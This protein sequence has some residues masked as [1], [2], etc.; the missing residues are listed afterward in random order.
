MYSMQRIVS[1]IRIL[2]IIMFAIV[3]TVLLSHCII[4]H[5]QTSSTSGREAKLRQTI[6]KRAARFIRL[7]E[8]LQDNRDITP[9]EIDFMNDFLKTGDKTLTNLGLK[10]KNKVGLRVN[11][12]LS[13]TPD[14]IAKFNPPA[15]GQA[16]P[17]VNVPSVDN[18]LRRFT[19]HY[20]EEESFHQSLL[21]QLLHAFMAKMEGVRNPQY[22]AKVLNFMLALASGGNRKAFEFVSANF[23]SVSLRHIAR[24]T[25][26]RRSE[27]FINVS[28]VDMVHRIRGYID[29]IRSISSGNSRSGRVA[30][31]VGI[32]ATV[33]VKAFQV[34]HSSQAIVGGAYPNHFLPIPERAAAV[35]VVSMLKDCVENKKYGLPAAEVK[36]CVISF[37][38][39]PPGICPYFP[40]VGRPQAVNENSSFG[41]DVLEACV[42]A[43]QEDG[44]AVVLNTS[45][46]GVSTEVKW[47][48]RVT[49][50]F[51]LGKRNQVSLPDTNHNVKNAR[52]QLIGGSSAAC[53]G[54]YVFDPSLLKLAKVNQKLW[55]VEDYASDALVL[56]LASSSTIQKL[57]GLLLG[58]E[59]CDLCSINPGSHAVTVVSLVF[60]RLRTYAVN[61]R[62]LSWMHR[63]WYIW[64]T[65][66][67][68]SSFHTA[69]STMM[70]NKRNML[71]ETIGILFLV[72]RDDVM[73]PRRN[74]SECNEHTFGM[75]RT[76]RREFNME[77]L[78]RIVQKSILRTNCIFEGNLAT[79]R[80][81]RGG[82]GYQA[83]FPDFIKSIQAEASE[84][85]ANCG[86]V[87][88][89]L[90]KPAV[91]QLWSVVQ[92]QIKSV[93]QKMKPFLKIFGVEEGNGLSPFACDIT[94]PRH[95]HD[96]TVEFFKAP[97]KKDN[98][99]ENKDK[100][101][102]DDKEEDVGGCSSPTMISSHV[103]EI[104]TIPSSV[105]NAVEQADTIDNDD[106]VEEEDNN[107]N[108]SSEATETFVAGAGG[109][110]GADTFHKCMELLGSDVIDKVALTA[111]A[112]IELLDLRKLDKGAVSSEGKFKS[113][114]E[115]WFKAKVIESPNGGSDNVNVNDDQQKTHQTKHIQRNSLIT[116]KCI[117]GG[118]ETIQ[119]FRVLSF[120]GKY[121]NKWFMHGSD[122]NDCHLWQPSSSA[123]KTSGVRMLVHLV[124]KV[125]V[126]S[127]QERTVEKDGEF[128]PADV[129]CI[130]P[131]NDIQS[132]VCDLED[133]Y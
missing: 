100:G 97:P 90:Q 13:F 96:L 23:C 62:G 126:T 49:L 28:K 48:L 50:D 63:V 82:S 108:G 77:Q 124:S 11:Y 84:M 17:S 64:L 102:D 51:L 110:I 44:N 106:D 98:T 61:A 123:S 112:L 9:S 40:L 32:D 16:S 65:F 88:V 45:T 103:H 46:D 127:F 87:H 12:Y 129:Y 33:L 24:L 6:G 99:G 54:Y 95:L 7:N 75:W 130:R 132:L 2:Y 114:R 92:G 56:Q 86:P 20:S 18:F 58:T 111:Q 27:P 122:D 30:M 59:F 76:I 60:L 22:G 25:A 66:I 118:K 52:Y 73:H 133:M 71:L 36:V 119:Y 29:K 53:F 125:G 109:S 47:N 26:V 113:L 55:R 72:T 42:L 1:V 120:F 4:N 85:N 70:P 8:I 128:G 14:I 107:T 83:T 131:L 78:V 19:K 81:K 43:A 116:L 57:N 121:Y 101:E 74:T 69:G 93:N 94:S 68:F 115:R 79:H 89:D 41:D 31:T 5:H 10:V 80:S 67:W 117:R 3:L 104:N 37:Q 39:T 34:C 21:V 105:E 38:D 35:D 91:D 15:P